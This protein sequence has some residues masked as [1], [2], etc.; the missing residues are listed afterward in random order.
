[1]LIEQSFS[2][3]GDSDVLLLLDTG[4]K[5][6]SVF[7]E[8]KVKS[9]QASKW[10]IHNEYDR[11]ISGTK[12]K[13]SSSNLFTQLYHKVRL[14]DALKNGG[15]E[16]IQTGIPFPSSSSKPVRKIGNNGV[17]LK[18]V[19]MLADYLDE[20]YYLAILPDSPENLDEFFRIEPVSRAPREYDGWHTTRYGYIAWSEIEA[21]CG[22][23]GLGDTLSVFRHNGGQIYG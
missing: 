21:F 8:A 7:I 9:Y 13:V 4:D 23:N 16:R 15:I 10:S 1:V 2:D 6:V 20:T 19:G 11:F 17:V 22:E 12:G 18:A 5:K 3:F 14:V